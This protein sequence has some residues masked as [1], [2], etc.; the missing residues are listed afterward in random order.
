MNS[1]TER[2]AGHSPVRRRLIVLA[3]AGGLA[4]LASTLWPREQTA[5]SGA[6]AAAANAPLK[7]GPASEVAEAMPQEAASADSPVSAERE[8]FARHQGEAFQ[9]ITDGAAGTTLVLDE[10]GALVRMAGQGHRFEG[11]SLLFKIQSGAL[12]GDGLFRIR[13]DALGELEFYLGSVG[14]P[15]SPSRCEAVVSRAV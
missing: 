7:V 1:E 4:G 5:E 12:P 11:Y 10:V 3:G 15:A 6:Q 2:A 13:H 8:R 14:G 9:V